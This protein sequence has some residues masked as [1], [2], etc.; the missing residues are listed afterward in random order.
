MHKNW[1]VV[2]RYFQISTA[3]EDSEWKREIDP[4][5]LFGFEL[6]VNL[7]IPY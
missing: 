1:D 5:L 7:E 6:L 3:P 4:I 2:G